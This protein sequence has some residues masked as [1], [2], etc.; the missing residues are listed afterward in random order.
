MQTITISLTDPETGAT[1]DAIADLEDS[2]ISLLKDY[3]SNTDKLLSL[4]IVKDGIPTNLGGI[5]TQGKEPSFEVKLPEEEKILSLLHRLRM[6]ILNDQTASYNKITG[7]ISRKFNNS[8]VRA[9]IKKHR[10][11]YDGL[12]FQGS[13]QLRVNGKII[14]SEEVLFLWLNSFEYHDDK[15]KKEEIEKLHQLLPLDVSKA[16]FLVI[17]SEKVKAILG[18][19]DF[20]SL[21]VGRTNTIKI[22]A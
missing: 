19:A 3:L 10:K 21:L 13:M 14:N 15:I 16:L 17:L 2:E 4:S 18:I 22:M 9:I 20:V 11:V 7:I 5:F 6:F 1:E 12:S 8:Y